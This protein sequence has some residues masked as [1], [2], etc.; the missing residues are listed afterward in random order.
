MD[1]RGDPSGK[2][3]GR[4]LGLIEYRAVGGCGLSLPGE[5]SYLRDQPGMEGNSGLRGWQPVGVD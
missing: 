5:E 2:I 3:T 4:N 1:N